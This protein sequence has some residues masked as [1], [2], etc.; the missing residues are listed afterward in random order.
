V[1]T[2]VYRVSKTPRYEGWTAPQAPGEFRFPARDM[3]NLYRKLVQTRLTH[4]H[5]ESRRNGIYREHVDAVRTLAWLEE[6]WLKQYPIESD[7]LIPWPDILQDLWASCR[8]LVLEKRFVSVTCPAC[9]RTYGPDEVKVL[10]WSQ[11][12]ELAASGGKGV[13]CPQGHGLYVIVEWDS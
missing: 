7:D 4:I 2:I 8:G 10:A 1:A 11:G 3:L 5:L 6:L 12:E 13:L 9:N